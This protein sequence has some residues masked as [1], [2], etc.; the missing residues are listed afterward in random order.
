MID[1]FLAEDSPEPVTLEI[2]D[3]TGN[4]VR[5]YS[6]TDK[7]VQPDLTKL[8]IPRYWIRPLQSLSTKRG[9]HRFL[10]DMHYAPIT[11]VEPEYPMTAI[12]RDT[13]PAPTSPW[14]MPGDYTVVLTANGK[15]YHAPAD[16]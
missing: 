11:G 9:M 3:K 1:Y 6:S 14:V 16:R 12:Y 10:W 8:K 2:K 13:P 4:L 7:P 15:R 5:R